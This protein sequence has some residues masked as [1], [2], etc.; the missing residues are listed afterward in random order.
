MK[1]SK[2]ILVVVLQTL[3]LEYFSSFSPRTFHVRNSKA[4]SSSKSSPYN[5]SQHKTLDNFNFINHNEIY[6]LILSLQ[7]FFQRGGT[8]YSLDGLP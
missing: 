6:S 1:L 8:E 4:A 2:V 5:S 7:C 3:D